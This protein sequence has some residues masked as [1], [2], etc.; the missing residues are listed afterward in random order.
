MITALASC[1]SGVSPL[2]VFF[3]V[4]LPQAVANIYPA[5]VSQVVITMLESAVV[6]Q[7]A[8]KRLTYSEL[9]GKVGETPE[10]TIA[11]TRPVEPEWEPF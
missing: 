7:I 11:A 10:P 6:S 2:S 3:D 9:T 5:L 1:V 8:G 4:V